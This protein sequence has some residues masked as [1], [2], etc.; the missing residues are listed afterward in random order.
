MRL[1]SCV[2]YHVLVE[3]MAS[4]ELLYGQGHIKRSRSEHVKE[5]ERPDEASD[6]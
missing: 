1:E 5:K 6:N 3:P 2:C 4:K